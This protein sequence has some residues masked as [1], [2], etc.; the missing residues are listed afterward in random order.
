MDKYSVPVK[1][2]FVTPLGVSTDFLTYLMDS[3]RLK[4]ALIKR[5]DKDCR[6]KITSK[7]NDNID[8]TENF[9][10]HIDAIDFNI[11]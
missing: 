4:R 1:Y 2:Y 6:S 7:Y 8:L 3:S 5:W 9:K 11:F 10:K